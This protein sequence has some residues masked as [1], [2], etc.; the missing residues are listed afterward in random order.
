MKETAEHGKNMDPISTSRPIV[1]RGSQGN[2]LAQ[3]LKQPRVTEVIRCCGSPSILNKSRSQSRMQTR[4]Q[5]HS[6]TE[7]RGHSSIGRTRLEEV[8]ERA[9][10]GRKHSAV[11]GGKRRSDAKLL[12]ENLMK[13]ISRCKEEEGEFGPQHGYC[14]HIYSEIVGR[15]QESH[16]NISREFKRVGWAVKEY[17]CNLDSDSTKQLESV[18]RLMHLRSE[19]KKYKNL[20]FD[21]DTIS[22]FRSG[23]ARSSLYISALGKKHVWKPSRYVPPKNV[24]LANSVEELDKLYQL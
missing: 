23:I 9:G 11:L 17:C 3:R 24:V 21:D 6:G 8:S 18:Q 10:P 22:R 13:L 15:D 7:T 1:K 16:A 14:L 2:L 5:T 20:L 19:K 12:E 4:L